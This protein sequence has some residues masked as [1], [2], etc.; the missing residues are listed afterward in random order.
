MTEPRDLLRLAFVMEEE[1]QKLVA[2]WSHVTRRDDTRAMLK[3]WCAAAGVA[4]RFAVIAWARSLRKLKIC[5]DDGTV[6]PEVEKVL[7]ANMLTRLAGRVG[8]HRRQP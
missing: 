6:D 1:A 2:A 8:G 7:A 4:D 3:E 5:R